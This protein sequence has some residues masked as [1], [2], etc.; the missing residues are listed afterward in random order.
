VSNRSCLFVAALAGALACPGLAPAKVYF[1]GW[2]RTLREEARLKDAVLV[3]AG[4]LVPLSDDPDKEATNLHVEQVLKAPRG[5]VA[6]VVTLS[7]YVLLKPTDP[8]RFVVFIDLHAGK[9]DPYRGIP[10]DK[11][12][13]RDYLKGALALPARDTKRAFRY[14]F[15]HLEH[16]NRDVAADAFA[17]M[18]KFTPAEL[19]A[20]APS[21]PATR[22]A[23]WLKPAA[24]AG[25]LGLYAV[26]LGHCGKDAHADLLKGL[27][28]E[29]DPPFAE[30]LWV[31]YILLRPAA[32]WADLWQTL[33][34]PRRHVRARLLAWKALRALRQDWPGLVNRK[35]ITDALCL[36]LAQEDVGDL[37][38]EDLRKWGCWDR[39]DH[40]LAVRRTKGYKV[41]LVRRAL[42]RYC[43]ECKGH[44][45]CA[46]F[47]AQRR[48]EDPDEVADT[49]ELLK[50]ERG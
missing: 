7:R 14:F 20:L 26:L 10:D 17:E 22:L 44:A 38:I 31:G 47:V 34:N 18:V 49:E 21:L 29:T 9:L 40:V 45:R 33:R 13:V 43:L 48:K 24:Q 15:A 39:A 32:G 11:G 35:A 30:G 6:K 46:A 23:R 37:G 42:L 25:R 3:L 50:L 16:A 2:Q 4:R 41:P 36:L 12:A 5:G 19:K 1:S 28:D 27:L 8:T